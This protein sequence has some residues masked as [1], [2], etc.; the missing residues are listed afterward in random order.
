LRLE[1]TELLDN[2]TKYL[3]RVLQSTDSGGT[4]VKSA[5]RVYRQVCLVGELRIWWKKGFN[6]RQVVCLILKA[7][8]PEVEN[9]GSCSGFSLNKGVPN[10]K[11]L[12]MH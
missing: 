10:P 9:R 11:R 7:F 5:K 2:E 12:L 8:V 4:E 1:I 3:K 6:L